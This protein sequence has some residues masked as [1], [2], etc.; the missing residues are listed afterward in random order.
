MNPKSRRADLRRCEEH[1]EREDDPMHEFYTPERL[2]RLARRHRL[3]KRLLYLLAFAALAVCVVLTCQVN[4]HNI[5]DMLLACI[6]ISVGAAWIIIYFGVYVVRDGGRELA[7]A[8]NL[9]DGPRETVTGT[10]T[11]LPLKV[12][13]RNS[14]TLRK[15]RV[16]TAK[17]PAEYSV[18][19][20]KVEELRRAGERLTL[21]TVHGYVVAWQ[22]AEEEAG[23]ADR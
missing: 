11:V 4:T 3:V 7:H 6:C 1:S 17:G 22:R 13:I 14:V 9:A 12:R 5:Y 10:V 20:D 18:Q 23:H 15:L 2:E 16:E 19:I 8:K 21:Y